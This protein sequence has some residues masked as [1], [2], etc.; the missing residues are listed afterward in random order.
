MSENKMF[1]VDIGEFEQDANAGVKVIRDDDQ[2][3]V[4]KSVLASEIVQP[5]R[6]QKTGK[7]IYAYKSA[8]ELEKATLTFD[9]VPI[10]ALSHPVGSH[11]EDAQDVNGKVKAPVFRKD[12]LDPKTKRPCRRGIVGE[13]WFYRDNAP[14]VKAGPFSAITSATVDAI[15]AGT[16]RDNSIGFSCVNV[17]AS[18]EWQGQRYDVVQTRI[19][20]NHLAAPI[21]RGRCPSPYCGISM[22]DSAVAEES[23]VLQD[24]VLGISYHFD[25]AH[26]TDEQAK[27]WLEKRS[28][29]DCPVCERMQEVGLQEVGR[30]L[31]AQYG[32][33]VLEV[34]EGN[35]LPPVVPDPLADAS[36]VVDKDDTIAANRKALQDL[37][38]LADFFS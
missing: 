3:L 25:K 28:F 5:Y 31:Y 13:L 34:I 35:P 21:E 12:L 33:D 15:K 1:V 38:S 30:R 4:V 14:E 20:G 11:I 10:K 7:L 24:A 8:E 22:A 36:D 23:I 29:K 16:L 27:G 17:S 6:D 32:G 37:H 19:F 2:Y 18:G 9:G 26:F